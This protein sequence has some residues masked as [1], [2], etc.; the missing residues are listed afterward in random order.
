MRKFIIQSKK[1]ETSIMEV[2]CEKVQPLE[3]PSVMW[4]PAGEYRASV[5]LPTTFH[6]KFERLVEGKKVVTMV[7]DVWHSHAFY[8]TLE[9]A[10][11]QVKDIILSEFKTNL[12]K[13]GTIINVVDL[14]V[15]YESVKII[16]L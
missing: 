10:Q 4:L 7:P 5:L 13:Y 1:E 11:A 2:E 16:T 3:D 14:N 6:Q 12:R 9:L 8:D 15:A